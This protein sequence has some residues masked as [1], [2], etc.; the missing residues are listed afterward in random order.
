MGTLITVG[1]LMF[2][3]DLFPN[4][5]VGPITASLHILFLSIFV[6]AGRWW[7]KWPALVLAV[8]IA[9]YAGYLPFGTLL[10][11]VIL[12]GIRWLVRK[13]TSGNNRKHAAKQP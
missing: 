2:N 1:N 3:V 8:G 9:Y 6:C 12:Y 11:V 7:L 5:F 4:P 10:V 13:F